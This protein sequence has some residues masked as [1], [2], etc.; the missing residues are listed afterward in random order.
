M[1][2]GQKY[3]GIGYEDFYKKLKYDIGDVEN[4]KDEKI[5]AKKKINLKFLMFVIS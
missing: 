2:D 3:D 5:K 1:V 4:G